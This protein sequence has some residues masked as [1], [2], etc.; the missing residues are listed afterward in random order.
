[1]R[2]DYRGQ[3]LGKQ[4]MEKAE[5]RAKEK[6]CSL[7]HLNTFDFQ[8]PEFYKKLGYTVFGELN[9]SPTGHKMYFLK[10]DI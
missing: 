2:Q 10:K 6:R 7:I 9:N 8:A 1:M 4:L 3:G 5:L